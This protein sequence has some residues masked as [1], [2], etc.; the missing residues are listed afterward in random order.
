[1][2]LFKKKNKKIDTGEATRVIRRM[3]SENIREYK[4]NYI[5]LA[6]LYHLKEMAT[7]NFII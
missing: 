2:S 1:M 4:K 6:D 5:M 7:Q 3:M